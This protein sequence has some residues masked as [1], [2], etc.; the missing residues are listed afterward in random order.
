MVFLSLS[1][2][3]RLWHVIQFNFNQSIHSNFYNMQISLQQYKDRERDRA[4]ETKEEGEGERGGRERDGN[5]ERM[6]ETRQ[7]SE[8]RQ[9]DGERPQGREAEGGKEIEVT[10]E[11]KRCGRAID[12]WIAAGETN[13]LWKRQSCCCSARVSLG[14]GNSSVDI[15][16]YNPSPPAKSL[17]MLIRGGVLEFGCPSYERQKGR[18][19]IHYP[20]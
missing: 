19:N 10:W 14:W 1:I 16:F 11:E 3:M 5:R 12:R 13:A 18:L 2:V 7:R 8:G 4:K 20:K 17:D 9:R 6:G 15:A